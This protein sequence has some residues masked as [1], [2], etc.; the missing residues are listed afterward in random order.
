LTGA[1]IAAR[2]PTPGIGHALA[3]LR[4]A[5]LITATRTG[6]TYTYKPTLSR[7]GYLAGLVAAALDQAADPAAVLRTALHTAPGVARHLR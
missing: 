4:A 3:Q 7:D 1:Q 6:R 5:A 2:L